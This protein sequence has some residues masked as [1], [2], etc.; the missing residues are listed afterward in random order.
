[1]DDVLLLS[2]RFLTAVDFLEVAH[3]DFDEVSVWWRVS[4]SRVGWIVQ[5]LGC[6]EGQDN[7]SFSV[8]TLL[9]VGFIEV[10]EGELSK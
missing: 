2:V 6:F 9:F 7:L 8:E 5:I 3:S 4:M 1:M 10:M